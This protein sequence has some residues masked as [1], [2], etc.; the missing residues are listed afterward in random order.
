MLLNDYYKGKKVFITGH[1]GFKGAWLTKWL[2]ELGAI[3]S[4]VSLANDNEDSMFYLLKLDKI[5]SHYE[6][7]IR[8]QKKLANAL[9]VETP[10]FIFHLAAQP[11]V[12]ESYE[13][14]FFTHSV[15]YNG[16]LNLLEIVRKTAF[17]KKLIVITSDKVYKPQSDF[18]ALNEDAPLGGI[19]P[20]SASKSAVEI[21]VSS[22]RE[23]YFNQRNI[24]CLTARA[25]NVIGYGDWGK[26]RLIPDVFRSIKNK[27]PIE[28]RN[29][30]SIRP[31]QD[32]NDICYGYLLLCMNSQ[33]LIQDGIYSMNFGP[34]QSRHTV[35]EMVE[36]SQRYYPEM[37][38]NYAKSTFQETNLLVLDT[39]LASQKLGWIVRSS[40]LDSMERTFKLL[41]LHIDSKTEQ[42]I[43]LIESSIW[44][45]I[46]GQ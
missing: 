7:D 36:I 14:P 29:P 44:D 18:I 42:L 35:L 28:L 22:Y 27:T 41:S 11:L 26:N 4:G 10:E 24:H 17:C 46:N 12:L 30:N 9:N 13:D 2:I 25:G 31:W 21:L 38:I 20:Y 1:T 6:F 3:V 37:L 33:H 45:H 39:S 34:N 8:D 40:V 15:N 43:T 16:T 5:V 32:V 19:D 23:S